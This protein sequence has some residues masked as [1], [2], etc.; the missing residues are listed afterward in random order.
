MENY[1]A[2][3]GS[4]KSRTK[5]PVRRALPCGGAKY[6]HPRQVETILFGVEVD[7]MKSAATV[8]YGGWGKRVLGQTVI[9]VYHRHALCKK[10][11]YS[12]SVFFLSDAYPSATMNV[13]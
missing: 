7:P 13:D 10:R 2:G 11:K 3:T 8:F 9:D 4:G 5:H 6:Y 1:E 12:Q